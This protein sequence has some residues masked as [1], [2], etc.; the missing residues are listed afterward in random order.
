MMRRAIIATTPKWMRT[1]GGI[2][3]NYAGDVIAKLV[4]RPFLRAVSGI[5]RVELAILDFTSP[6]TTPI[7][8]PAPYEHNHQDALLEF[9]SH[10]G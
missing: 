5:P 10:T 2:P 4:A 6:H 1:L 3:Q 9:E 8:G 7:V